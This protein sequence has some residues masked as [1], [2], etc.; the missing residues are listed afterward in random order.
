MLGATKGEPWLGP[1]QMHAYAAARSLA[2]GEGL[3]TR[4]YRLDPATHELIAIPMV[5]WPPVQS[6]L[7]AGGLWCNISPGRLSLI[8]NLLSLGFQ[9][10]LVYRL[11]RRCSGSPAVGHVAAALAVSNVAFLYCF[12][13]ASSEMLFTPILLWTLWRAGAGDPN[14]VPWCLERGLE[15]GFW[16]GMAFLTRYAG[17][18][19]AVWV[20]AVILSRAQG[21]RL[22]TLAGFALAAGVL[23]AL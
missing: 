7:L 20:V 22:R 10:F 4:Q 6:V 16:T 15:L 9:A 8:V 17:A 18:I 12:H 13:F 23:W 2:G 3:H 14:P 11:A 5:H 1:D 21:T 19:L